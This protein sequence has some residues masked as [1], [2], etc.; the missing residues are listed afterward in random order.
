MLWPKYI[1]TYIHIYIYTYIHTHIHTHTYT[2]THARLLHLENFSRI[3]E[4]HR[5]DVARKCSARYPNALNAFS[6]CISNLQ[7]SSHPTLLLCAPK[8][9]PLFKKNPSL[10]F[11]RNSRF[12]FFLRAANNSDPPFKNNPPLTKRKSERLTNGSNSKYLN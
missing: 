2:H 1:H 8:M 3:R 11:S 6:N 7:G 12:L 10:L 5:G 9:P 4:N